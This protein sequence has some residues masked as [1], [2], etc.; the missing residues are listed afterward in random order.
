MKRRLLGC[1]GIALFGLL[2]SGSSASEQFCAVG[3]NGEFTHIDST[4]GEIPPSRTDLPQ[5]MQA[6]AYDPTGVLYACRSRFLT[7]TASLY[8]LHPVTGETT[9]S[10]WLDVDIRGIAFSPGGTLYASVN[11]SDVVAP[12]SHLGTINLSTGAYTEIGEF[13]GDGTEAQGMAFSP[14]GVLFAIAPDHFPPPFAYSLFTVD[15]GDARMHLVGRFEDYR[16]AQSIAFTPSGNLYA[17]GQQFARLNPA[18][19][20]VV[21]TVLDLSGDYRGLE[22]ADLPSDVKRWS[23]YE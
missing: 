2:I 4:I 18:T 16:M 12:P 10:L 23:L 3:W 13:W 15:T 11:T 1:L 5:Y 9:H 19:G 21:G 22:W 8:T 6:L 20:A 14:T 7:T 17:L